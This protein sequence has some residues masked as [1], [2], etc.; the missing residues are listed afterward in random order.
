MSSFE[1]KK[2]PDFLLKSQSHTRKHLDN[3]YGTAYCTGSKFT[4]SKF[5]YVQKKEKKVIKKTGEK[6]EDFVEIKRGEITLSNHSV[7][8]SSDALVFLL[9]VEGVQKNLILF[10]LFYQMKKIEQT[11]RWNNK[12]I[13][14]FLVFCKNLSVKEPTVMSVKEA[15]KKLSQKK[16]VSSIRKGVYQINPILTYETKREVKQKQLSLF[17]ENSLLKNKIVED[18][19]FPLP[20]SFL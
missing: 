7:R 15:M 14:E 6:D 8:L 12:V 9:C 19:L 20:L 10:I 5:S 2:S 17:C 1:L 11:F 18:E 16:I 3:I 13:D 4:V